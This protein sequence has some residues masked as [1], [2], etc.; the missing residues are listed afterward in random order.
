MKTFNKIYKLVEQIPHGKVTTYGEISNYLKL[1]NPRIVGFAL[2]QNKN[3]DK[4]PCHRV[5]NRRGQTAKGY[6]FGGLGVQRKLLE[7][8][9]IVFNDDKINL[10]KYRYDLS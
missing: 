10:K 6:A 4:V 1:Q 8:E 9:G 2:H 5:V 7:A 3:P